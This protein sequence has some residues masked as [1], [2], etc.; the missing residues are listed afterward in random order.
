MD[1]FCHNF[2]AKVISWKNQIE[3]TLKSKWIM[4]YEVVKLWFL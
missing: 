2:D 3:Q 4:F 1:Q